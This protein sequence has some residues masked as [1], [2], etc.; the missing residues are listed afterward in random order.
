MDGSL[1]L[2]KKGK[3]RQARLRLFCLLLPL[4]LLA[5]AGCTR[6]FY[7]KQ[8]DKEVNDI[9]VEKDKNPEWKIEQYHVY[10]DPRARFANP[11]NP[12]RPPMPPD[13]P[14][15]WKQSPHPQQPGHKGVGTDEGTG[16]LD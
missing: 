11:N 5:F 4:G 13:D 14:T 15:A 1:I 7:R 8:A 16:Y 6:A 2:G 9:L 10:P 12:D 3:T